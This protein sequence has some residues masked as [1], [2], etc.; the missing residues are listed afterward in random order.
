MCMDSVQ[1]YWDFCLYDDIFLWRTI[2][3]GKWPFSHCMC[4][5]FY[6]YLENQTISPLWPHKLITEKE[7]DFSTY[8]ISNRSYKKVHIHIKPLNCRFSFV[9]IRSVFLTKA[10][11][12]KNTFGAVLKLSCKEVIVRNTI[13]LNKKELFTSHLWIYTLLGKLFCLYILTFS[14]IKR[15]DWGKRHLSS[16]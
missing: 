3:K 8:R 15:N 16:F 9:Y 10:N 5:N 7:R 1:K 6:T 14:F 2:L 12:W 4:L 11:S 13:K